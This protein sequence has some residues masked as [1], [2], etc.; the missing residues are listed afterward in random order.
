MQDAGGAN[1]EG[2]ISKEWHDYR[3]NLLEHKNQHETWG[4]QY[5]SGF[6]AITIGGGVPTVN[7]FSLVGGTIRDEDLH[8]IISNPQTQ[9]RIAYRGTGGTALIFDAAG[10]T[11]AKVSGTIPYYDNNGTLTTLAGNQY[12]IYWIYA[13]TRIATPIVSVM[14]QGT[15]SNI[16]NAQAA[17]QPTLTG[18]TTAEWKLLYRVI[19]R[20]AGGALTWIQSDPLYNVSTGPAINAGTV[21]TVSASNVSYVPTSPDTSTNV[22]N[23]LNNRA[24]LAGNSAQDFAIKNVTV[25]EKA[26]FT[27]GTVAAGATITIPNNYT[28]VSITDDS[29]S[30]ANSLIMP[31]GSNGQILWVYNGDAQATS[32]DYIIPA[33]YMGMF[34]YINGWKLLRGIVG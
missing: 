22:Q 11:Y 6:N 15:Y 3:R 4:S 27:V 20:N 8:Q 10:T 2:I 17:P 12:G 28:I 30:A 14:G 18:I 9:C 7:S 33:G 5:V 1:Y 23:A 19:V 16:A 21:A 26:T 24:L 25:A 34:V 31:S 29:A 32:G 13:T